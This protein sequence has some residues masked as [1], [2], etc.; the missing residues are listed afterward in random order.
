MVVGGFA[1]PMVHGLLWGHWQHMEETTKIVLHCAKLVNFC[2]QSSY[3]MV[4]GEKVTYQAKTR[5]A[6]IPFN[7]NLDLQT[8]IR[9]FLWS[10]FVRTRNELPK[11][12]SDK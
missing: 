3:L 8:N 11:T 5:Y 12:C 4:V 10:L 2:Y 1:T 9:E 6:T 7:L